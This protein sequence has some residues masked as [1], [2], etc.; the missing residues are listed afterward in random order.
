M[1][2]QLANLE[3]QVG[4]NMPVT[5]LKVLYFSAFHLIGSLMA[6]FSVGSCPR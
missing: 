3:E 4:I 5:E 1:S 6:G 2:V